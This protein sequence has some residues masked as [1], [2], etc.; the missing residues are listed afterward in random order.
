MY[1]I[2]K[3]NKKNKKFMVLTPQQKVV[4]YG[5]TSYDDYT[6][7]QDPFRKQRY[8]DRHKKREDWSN[9]NKAGTWSRY[10]LWNKPTENESLQHMADKFNIH[11]MYHKP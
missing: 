3:S 8:I 7:H 4:H 6:T 2:T 11:I 1:H 5:H 10:H 9:L